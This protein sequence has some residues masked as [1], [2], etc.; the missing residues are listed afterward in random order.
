MW[1]LDLINDYLWTYVMIAVLLGA[2]LFFTL[3]TR[4][5]QFVMI[6]QMLKQLLRSGK[7]HENPN[8]PTPRNRT[9]SS[10]QAFAVSIAGRVGTGNIA[11]VAIAIS[12]GGPGA[13]FWMWVVALLGAASA[14]VESTLAQVFKIRERT[15]FRGGPAYYILRGLKKRWWAMTFAMLLTLT[16][17]LANNT[18]QINTIAAA[19]NNA[20][21]ISPIVTGIVTTLLVAMVIWGGIHRISRVSEFLVP[22]MALAYIGIA[23]YVIISNI[24][25]FPHVIAMIIENAFGMHQVIGGGIGSAILLGVKRGLFSNEAGEGSAPNVAAAADVSHPVKQGLIQSLG[26]YTDTLLICSATAFIILCSGAVDSGLTGVELT[27]TS[28][29]T[30][31]GPVAKTFIAVAIYLFAFSTIIANY[32]YSETNLEFINHRPSTLLIFRIVLVILLLVG[33]V[34]ALNVVWVVADICMALMTLCNIAAILALGKIALICLK[35]YRTQLRQGVD[36]VFTW[37]HLPGF[38]DEIRDAWPD[39]TSSSPKQALDR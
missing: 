33:S 27:Q 37:K 19:T 2:A 23:I 20:F 12:M 22:I 35:D 30:C 7:A 25:L 38:K 13:V 34:A 5:V 4:G 28:L 29:E 9:I 11:G 17:G 24:H 18:V 8:D 36:P 32:Y 6:P 39:A 14:F 10:F 21:G 3:Y 15:A 31:I 1:L 26:V 16:F